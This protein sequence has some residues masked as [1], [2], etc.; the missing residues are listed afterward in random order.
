MSVA[1]EKIVLKLGEKKVDLSL[2]EA[3]KLYSMLQEMFGNK[4]VEVYN[5]QRDQIL[6]TNQSLDMS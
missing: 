2:E 1:I 3:R 6:C 5:H 4:V